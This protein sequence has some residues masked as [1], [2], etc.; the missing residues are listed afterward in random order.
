MENENRWVFKAEDIFED[1]PDDPANVNLN[2]PEEI[3]KK[4]GLV[5]GDTVKVLVGDQGTLII[6]KVTDGKE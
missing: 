3:A 4:I 6:E 2:I 5:P 1:I